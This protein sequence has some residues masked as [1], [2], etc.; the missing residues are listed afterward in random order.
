MAENI[1]LGF[2]NFTV[3]HQKGKD[4]LNNVSGYVVKGG[5][6]AILG[7]SASGKSVLLQA[8]AGRIQD[9]DI[10]GDVYMNNKEVD[11]KTLGNPSELILIQRKYISLMIDLQ[12]HLSRKT[13]V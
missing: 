1:A 5:I 13:I 4:I 3:R 11:P 2:K 8:L 10:S 9:L 6:T 7:A 12:L